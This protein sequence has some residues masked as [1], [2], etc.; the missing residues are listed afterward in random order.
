MHIDSM[1]KVARTNI[2]WFLKPKL[3]KN[4]IDEFNCIIDKLVEE[5][6]NLRSLPADSFYKWAKDKI[7][8]NH[9]FYMQSA[10]LVYQQKYVEEIKSI[11]KTLEIYEQHRKERG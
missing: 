6:Y 10:S 8:E 5:K 11:E 2:L 1:S 7:T 4:R 9:K 3:S